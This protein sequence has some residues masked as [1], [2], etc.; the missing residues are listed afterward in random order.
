MNIN[1]ANE[2]LQK[3]FTEDVLTTVQEEYRAEGLAWDLITYK[4]NSEV[5]DLLEG[6][7]G[8]FATLNEECFVPQGSDVKYLAKIIK[9][10]GKHPCFSTNV[11]FGKETFIIHHYAGKVAYNVI[12]FVD[13]NKDTLPSE[14]KALILT[15]TNEVLFN[16]FNSPQGVP[17]DSFKSTVNSEG[18]EISCAR[19]VRT[20]SNRV[21]SIR[22]GNSYLKSET[23]TT[24]FKNQL[25]DLMTA[26]SL[27]DVQ[28][29]RCI[30]PNPAKSST[31]FDRLMVVEQLR[32]AGMIEAIRISR[33]AYPYRITHIEFLA[34]FGVLKTKQWLAKYGGSSTASKCK[35]I[36]SDALPKGRGAGSSAS[37]GAVTT[38]FEIGKTRIYFSTGVL[39]VLEDMRSKIIARSVAAMQRMARGFPIRKK[40]QRLRRSAVRA[41]AQIR[42]FLQHRRF[43]KL[44]AGVINIQCLLRQFLAK[45]R[46]LSARRYHRCRLL[47]AV[48]RMTVARRRYRGILCRCC[49]IQSLARMFIQRRKYLLLLKEMKQQADLRAQVD[50]LRQKLEEEREAMERYREETSRLALAQLDTLRQELRNEAKPAEVVSSEKETQTDEVIEKPAVA[51]G[52]SQTDEL[53]SEHDMET[54]TSLTSK[55][56]DDAL[57]M[58]SDSP[59]S[60]NVPRSTE[61]SPDLKSPK[62][63]SLTSSVGLAATDDASNATSTGSFVSNLRSVPCPPSSSI[64]NNYYC[65]KQ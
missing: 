40:Y 64:I 45:R 22:R 5:L 12:G 29:V 52:E 30:K 43:V 51:C 10:H 49:R 50:I 3:K 36:L 2:K 16:I 54:Q 47:Q 57:K 56:I 38:P 42:A 53:R 6:R 18:S 23:V 44:V 37:S 24:K 39:E 4:D 27:T 63:I 25:N 65:S 11:H 61:A 58:K 21:T 35:V 17:G 26:I 14:V 62:R 31:L 1:Y 33:A 7:V 55:D 59:L 20:V 32:C 34:R 19:S 28:Y 9:D 13:K 48:Y 8:L 41:Q 46:V 60:L 15:S